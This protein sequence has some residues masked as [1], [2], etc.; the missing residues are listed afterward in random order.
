[1]RLLL[2]PWHA[3]TLI[4]LLVVIAIIA[5]LIALLIPAVQ[6]VREAAARTQ[7]QNNLKQMCLAL[8]ACNDNY[9]RLPPAVGCFPSNDWSFRN[10]PN[11]GS[12]PSPYGPLQYYMLPYL[13]QDNVYQTT[14]INWSAT[15]NYP[16]VPVYLA[17]GD[18]T[19]PANGVAAWGNSGA[20]SY[21][22][23]LYVFGTASG[24]S[25][26]SIPK[27]FRDGTS[28]TIVFFERY[29]SCQGYEHTWA[30]WYWALPY[31]PWVGVGGNDT[32]PP[33][34]TPGYPPDMRPEWAPMDTQCTYT[35]VQS[36]FDGGII[37][38]LGDGSV[39]VVTPDITAATWFYAINPNDG[40]V[41]GP[42]W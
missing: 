22:S 18:P 5:I 36:F 19:A 24:F 6:K 17:P 23:N 32:P 27:T 31:W 10:L 30:D 3:F 33:P 4:E 2:K 11:W 38:G 14:S 26:A 13:E 16:V 37:V 34:G 28:S 12:P 41:L 39:R 21:A 9:K 1:M 25:K 8:H 29:A 40:Q 20:M 15:W 7:S 42:D 35:N